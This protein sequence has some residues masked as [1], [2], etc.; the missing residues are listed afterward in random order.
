V[1]ASFK[2]PSWRDA[3]AAADRKD[4]GP[5]PIS[6]GIGR[7]GIL[8]LPLPSQLDLLL[9][10]GSQLDLGVCFVD[11]FLIWLPIRWSSLSIDASWLFDFKFANGRASCRF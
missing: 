6:T 2:E 7:S 11:M 9:L 5:A 8:V 3:A 1:T 10:L 4:A